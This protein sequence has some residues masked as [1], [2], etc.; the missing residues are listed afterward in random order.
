MKCC[1]KSTN[2]GQPVFQFHTTAQWPFCEWKR[3]HNEHTLSWQFK[4]FLQKFGKLIALCIP[5]GWGFKSSITN[6]REWLI[7]KDIR[8]RFNFR[9]CITSNEM[10]RWLWRVGKDFDKGSRSIF[11]RYYH[12]MCLKRL[13]TTKNPTP[14]TTV[15]NLD[16]MGTG[17]HP[18][19][20][21]QRYVGQS[22][23]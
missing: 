3:N 9:C 16:E 4:I 13:R 22:G 19:T 21:L 2:V 15:G 7:L 12:G 11:Q 1:L 20:H 8:R 17:F 6:V 18:N 5:I 10:G 14:I 23:F